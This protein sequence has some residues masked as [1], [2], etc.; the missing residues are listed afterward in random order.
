MNKWSKKFFIDLAERVGSTFL[1]ALLTLVAMD[2]ILEGPDWDTTLWPILVLPTLVSLLK[3]L[4]A[5][6]AAPETGASL[7]PDSPPGPKVNPEGG[8]TDVLYALGIALIVLAVALLVTTLLKVFVVG[9]VVLIVLAVIGF[10][11]IFW[12]GGAFLR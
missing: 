5:N 4:L 3:G 9:W 11:L 10:F 1:G 2:N 6:M 12:R 8:A 7:V